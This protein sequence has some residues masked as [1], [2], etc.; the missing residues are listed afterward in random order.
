MRRLFVSHFLIYHGYKSLRLSTKL[1]LDCLRH[2]GQNVDTV[3]I[4]RMS[5]CIRA[6]F[7]F[8]RL[9]VQLYTTGHVTIIFDFCFMRNFCHKLFYHGC[10]SQ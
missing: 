10:L 6:D 1:G 7:I 9:A 8:D 4:G 3:F 5:D 2:L